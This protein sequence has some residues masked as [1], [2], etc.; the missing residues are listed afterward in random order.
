MDFG[1]SALV[2]VDEPQPWLSIRCAVD[3]YA[4]AIVPLIGQ[5]YGQHC[6]QRAWRDFTFGSDTTFTVDDLHTELFFSWLFHTW[7]PL[8]TKGDRLNDERLYGI[9]PTRA[10]LAANTS[11]LDPLLRRYLEAC[12]AAPLGFYQV[13]DCRPGAGFRVRDLRGGQEL[14]VNEGL[15]SV[16]LTD[17]DIVL[18]RLPSVDA[19]VLVDAISPFSFPQSFAPKLCVQRRESHPHRL[20]D[21]AAR[22][23][24]F[25][26]LGARL[27]F[28]AQDEPRH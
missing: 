10:Y 22:T 15:A 4:S 26:L 20:T 12:L 24:Y 8:L 5:S 13:L 6:I 11:D 25:K 7:A 19:V 2:L 27:R 9:S 1:D 14:D 3:G 16:S 23:L 21:R 17:G 18:A 28:I